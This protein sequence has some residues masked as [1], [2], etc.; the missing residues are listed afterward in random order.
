MARQTNPKLLADFFNKIGQERHFAP[1]KAARLSRSSVKGATQTSALG[2]AMLRND[3][4]RV[5]AAGAWSDGN[6]YRK[7]EIHICF[8]QHSI[9]VAARGARRAAQ[10][11][12]DHRGPLR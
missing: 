10:K 5:T 4:M 8:R 11:A 9:R 7:A 1:Q 3:P 6:Q 12:T 2:R